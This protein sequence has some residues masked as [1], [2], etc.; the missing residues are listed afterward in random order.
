M[1]NLNQDARSVAR[2]WIASAGATMGQVQ[3]DLNTFFDD[4]VT[5]LTG[6]AGDEP[7]AAGVMLMRRMVEALSGW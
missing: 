2:F 5:F 7:D 1:R 4:V 3:K 6:N